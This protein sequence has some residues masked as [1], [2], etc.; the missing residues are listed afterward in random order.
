[1]SEDH[2]KTIIGN[3][4]TIVK[5]LTPDGILK[6]LDIPEKENILDTPLEGRALLE[7][8]LSKGDRTFHDI[9]KA[10]QDKNTDKLLIDTGRFR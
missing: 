4:N 5:C 6:L 10:C 7:L 1:M 3:F 2:K 8:I 9:I